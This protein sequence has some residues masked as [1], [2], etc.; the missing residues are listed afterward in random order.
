MNKILGNNIENSSLQN[1]PEELILNNLFRL[2]IDDI[3]EL[4]RSSK[5]IKFICDKNKE[6]IYRKLLERDFMIKLSSE[7]KN[8]KLLYHSLMTFS[9]NLDPDYII[10]ENTHFMLLNSKL[11]PG[12]IFDV[13]DNGESKL[14]KKLLEFNPDIIN[15]KSENEG[16]TLLHHLLKT[17]LPE[18]SKLIILNELL[19]FN[20][21]KV[22]EMVDTLNKDN[23]TGLM[24]LCKTIRDKPDLLIRFIQVSKNINQQDLDGNTALMYYLKSGSPLELVYF[25]FMKKNPNL[26]LE[27]KKGNTVFS[28]AIKSDNYFIMRDLFDKYFKNHLFHKNKTQETYLHKA[29]KYFQVDT[30]ELLLSKIPELINEKDK[31]GNIALHVVAWKDLSYA[32]TIPVNTIQNTYESLIINGSDVNSKNKTGKTPF[33]NFVSHFNSILNTSTFNNI[34]S[35]MEENGANY[36]LKDENG[37]N[38]LHYYLSTVPGEYEFELIEN[39]EVLLSHLLD[40]HLYSL[41]KE[42]NT[43]LHWFMKKVYPKYKS[44]ER[45]NPE[46]DEFFDEILNVFKVISKYNF[47]IKDRKGRTIKQFLLENVDN[48]ELNT[49]N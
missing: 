29:A 43:P 16:N 21:K 11:Q 26:S 4:C 6:Y 47:K 40:K 33:M 8:A 35:L 17:D 15:L 27:N 32:E 48:F 3:N 39:L 5:K 36:D 41:D 23:K 18:T 2:Q 22:F 13:I 49:L 42:G 38:I 24:L 45:D 1:L 37:Y 28:Y 25:E 14:V 46:I 31:D 34:L 7:S 12:V 10:S 30:I 44:V 19:Q 20:E 9:Y